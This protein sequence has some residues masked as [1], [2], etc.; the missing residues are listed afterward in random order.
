MALSDCPKCWE[1]PCQ[2]GWEY[3]EY[4]NQEMINTI[5]SILTYK[6]RSEAIEILKQVNENIKQKK[7]EE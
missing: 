4:N 5:T 6:N 7:N 2:C 3:R 1:T